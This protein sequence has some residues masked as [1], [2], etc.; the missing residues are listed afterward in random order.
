MKN[1]ILSVFLT[2]SISCLAQDYL[3]QNYIKGGTDEVYAQRNMCIGKNGNIYAV[4]MYNGTFGIQGDTITG[5]GIY[6]VKLTSDLTLVWLKK[7]ASGVSEG[8]LSGPRI[9]VA[10]D[11]E[12]NVLIGFSEWG[13]SNLKYDDSIITNTTNV[14]LIK[15]DSSGTRLW[16]TAV[17][18]SNRLGEKGLAVDKQNNI[19][20]TGKNSTD[21]V[22]LSKYDKNG[23]ELWYK[24]AGVSGTNKEDM[25]RV[26]TTDKDNNIYTAGQLFG[27]GNIETAYFGTHQVALPASCYD[28]TYLAKYAA[29]GTLQW[30]QYL[31]SDEP[32]K[33]PMYYGSSTIT[34]LECFED[35]T[36]AVG[37]YFTNQQ[38]LFSKDYPLVEKNGV[39][40]NGGTRASFLARFGANG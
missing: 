36:L 25:G 24:T 32:T 22:F 21:D 38:L 3:S 7:V 37:G 35:G 10:L 39:F 17:A 8:S 2:V 23:N 29:D 12:E 31:Y 5:G 40:P 28:P 6:L 26:V 11:N 27:I 1:L 34:S 20:I 14:E 4:G 16:R 15:L 18:G 30:M 33:Y 19:L 9:M 13:G